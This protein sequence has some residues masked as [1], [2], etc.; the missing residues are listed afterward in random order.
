M[1]DV[2]N[3]NPVALWPLGQFTI[4]G[5]TPVPLTQNVGAQDSTPGA[6][7][8]A[9]RIR[10]LIFS[11]AIADDVG[12]T[13]YLVQKGHLATEPDNV[14][15]AMPTVDGTADP[16]VSIPPPVSIPDGALLQ[17]VQVTPEQYE[18]DCDAG[19]NVSVWVTAIYG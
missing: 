13:L 8:M 4:A 18:L 6:P 11:G 7:L 10:Q 5:G 15:L 12:V 14:V 2:P 17:T 1:A 9:R 16:L 19:K 3:K